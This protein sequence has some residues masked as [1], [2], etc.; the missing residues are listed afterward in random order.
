MSIYHLHIPRNSG[1]F[2]REEMIK[3]TNK[4]M[5]VGHR[6]PIPESFDGHEYLSG[7]FATNPVESFDINFA[8]YREP[9]SLTFSY[10]S[11]MKDNF[12]PHLS[13]DQLIDHYIAT[14]K[15]KNFVNINSK[16]LTGEMDYA[17]YNKMIT[18]LQI[19]AESCWY[20]TSDCNDLQLFI[21]TIQKNNTILIDYNDEQKYEKISRLYDVDYRDIIVNKSS[22]MDSEV[23]SKYK[24]LVSDLN[25]FD[26]EVYEYLK[27]ENS[28]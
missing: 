27:S 6:D 8:L 1:V 28:R 17:K 2:I 7:H 4:P 11:Y 13:V 12:Y 26:L 22:E 15:M 23:F 19:V 14:D 3:K 9:V 21:E 24:D 5:F 25:S 10:I 18:D 16:F 20:V